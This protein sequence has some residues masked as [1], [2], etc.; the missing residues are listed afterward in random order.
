MLL[1]RYETL[2]S[3]AFLC[4][5][6]IV[7]AFNVEE[8]GGG[9]ELFDVWCNLAILAF[10]EGQKSDQVLE[11][12]TTS[13]RAIIRKL[14]LHND[15][16]VVSLLKVD[17]IAVLCQKVAVCLQTQSKVNLLQ[18]LGTLGSMAAGTEPLPVLDTTRAAVVRGVG[19]V[20]L[21]TAC[22]ATD[23]LIVAEA[24]DAIFD[25]FKEDH[26]DF[27]AVEILLV[28]RLKQLAPSYKQRVHAQR[29][30]PSDQFPVV[31]TVKDNL[32]R[33]IKY[34]VKQRAMSSR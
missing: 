13:M 31:M 28:E 14:S 10:Q 2:Q 20:L 24:L 34:K 4:L 1:K 19:Q 29:R 33:F 25:V 8:V 30:R 9:K 15:D 11:A 32:M 18:I 27:I 21:D 22:Q 12:A 16:M 6:N 26:V 3:R 5:S 23:L 17:D 7:T